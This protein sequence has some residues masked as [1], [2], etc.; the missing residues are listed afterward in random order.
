MPTESVLDL[1]RKRCSVR[2]FEDRPI[3]RE[4][5]LQ[6]MES[7][8]IAPSAANR[9]PWQFIVI[10]DRTLIA[11]ISPEWVAA[12]KAPVL[13]V[14]CGDHRQAWRRRDGKDHTDIDIA[15]AVDHMTLAAA[16]LGLGTCWICSFDAFRCA[17]VLELPDHLEPVVLL[18]IGYPA[19]AKAP[20]R[21]AVDRKP[22]E[23]IVSH[24]D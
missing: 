24:R 9:Q 5:L 11:Q 10:K 17:T 12:S 3:D 20:D 8:R 2:K 4:S 18:P 21:H 16:E 15:I 14:A 22:L 7:A 6:V 23:E 1:M 13:I 19:E